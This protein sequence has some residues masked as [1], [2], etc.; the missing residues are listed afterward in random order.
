MRRDVQ[1]FEVRHAFQAPSNVRKALD[2]VSLGGAVV[3][4]PNRTSQKAA[5]SE[6]SSPGKTGSFAQEACF[7]RFS[8][9]ALYRPVASA[10]CSF[11][12]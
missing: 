10:R 3:H 4:V 5:N 9:Y 11:G 12:H 8:S 6:G 1:P 2:K 7:R